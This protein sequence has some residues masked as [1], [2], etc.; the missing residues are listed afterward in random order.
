MS[1]VKIRPHFGPLTPA[2]RPGSADDKLP[3]HIEFAAGEAW[4]SF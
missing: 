2:D 4:P 3:L 1:N